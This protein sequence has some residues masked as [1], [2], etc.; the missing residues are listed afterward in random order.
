MTRYISRDEYIEL[1]RIDGVMEV[2]QWHTG[3]MFY[4]FLN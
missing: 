3:K 2:Y 1:F 4:I